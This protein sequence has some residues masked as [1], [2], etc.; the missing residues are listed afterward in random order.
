MTS[1]TTG[2]PFL[3]KASN[4]SSDVCQTV[5]T[6]LTCATIPT[7][8]Q[9]SRQWPSRGTGSGFSSPF[10]QHLHQPG[11]FSVHLH[12]AETL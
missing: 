8:A 9:Q 2:K 5:E 1:T 12:G 11:G 7:H 6:P 4:T 10:P 3:F